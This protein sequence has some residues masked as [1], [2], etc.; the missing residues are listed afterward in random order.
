MKAWWYRAFGS[1]WLL[2]ACAV[3]YLGFVGP[4]LISAANTYAVV[5]GLILLVLL[6]GWG[7]ALFV[8]RLRHKE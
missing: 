2:A 7:Y 6:A 8:R 3:L 1:P 4:Q 5:V